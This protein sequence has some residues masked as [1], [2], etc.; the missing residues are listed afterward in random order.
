VDRMASDLPDDVVI[1]PNVQVVTRDRVDDVDAIVVTPDLVFAVETKD[2]A[3]SVAVQ[4]QRMIVDG[5]DRGNPYLLTNHKSRRMGG[6][7]GADPRLAQAMVRPLVVLASE[8]A[9]AA[10]RRGDEA[11]GREPRPS[12]RDH[13]AA[14]VRGSRARRPGW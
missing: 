1:Y 14:V 6:K 3:G 11:P 8:A 12:D 5:E 13:D 10:D 4:E 2:L 9:D 7:L